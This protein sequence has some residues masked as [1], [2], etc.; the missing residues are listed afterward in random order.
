MLRLTFFLLILSLSVT[1]QKALDQPVSIQVV[2]QPLKAVLGEVEKQGNFYFSYSTGLFA[3][4]SL[5]TLI[6]KEKKVSEK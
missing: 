2:K 3:E 5:V 6:V 1:A 4:D